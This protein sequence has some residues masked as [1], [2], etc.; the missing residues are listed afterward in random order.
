MVFSST[1]FLFLF[2]PAVLL[3]YFICRNRTW[4][5]FVLLVFSVGF[6]A[7]GEPV[8]VWIMLAMVCVNWAA[9]RRMDRLD[10]KA[11]TVWCAVV[12]GADLLL[13]F[14]YKYAGFV[15]MNVRRLFPDSGLAVDIAL[16]IGISF[17]VFQMLSYVFDVYY[18]TCSAQKSVWKTMLY[19]SFF[20]Q[21]IAG[22]I[23][24]YETIAEE[25][26]I[27]K[28][29]WTDFSEG[30]IRFTYGLGKKVLLSNYLGYFAD[31]VFDMS[32]MPA[33]LTAW[34]GAGLYT[35][36]IYYDFS[37]YSDM[38]IGLGR[39]FGFRFLEN[40]NAP[41][42]SA[43]VTEFWRRWHMSLGSWFRDY[44]YIPLG[45]NRVGKAR[46][47]GN[48]FIVWLLTGMWHGANWTFVIWGLYYFVFL[49]FEKLA[50]G[51]W[52]QEHPLFGH[53]YTMLIV[54][55][56]W[57]LFRCESLTQAVRYLKNMVGMGSD[58]LLDAQTID[59]LYKGRIW[60]FVSIALLFP[61]R[62][63]VGKLR[64]HMSETA[65]TVFTVVSSAAVLF[66]SVCCCIKSTYAP[67]IYFNF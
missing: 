15:C 10:G 8:F 1:V 40:F 21:L 53:V 18:G 28:E 64:L 42:L 44:V 2:L 49:L 4:R 12:T 19:V 34:L 26:D 13:L 63:L 55:V 32:A 20:P 16:P 17:F 52:L 66:L 62:K 5:N 33:V 6:Y 23:V 7:W 59:L 51:T 39:M 65:E 45:G 47:I 27:R 35:L 29:T 22:P 41:Y 9:V 56:G 38:A 36:Q 43:S 46:W 50:I 60:I 11:R 31:Q 54:V 58:V 57:V 25:L 3:C 67:F 48:L 30:F 61:L 24:R 37:G 14:V